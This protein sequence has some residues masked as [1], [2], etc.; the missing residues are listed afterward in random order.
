ML[1]VQW[2]NAVFGGLGVLSFFECVG[3]SVL[4]S[5]TGREVGQGRVKMCGG[6]EVNHMR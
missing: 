5:F 3:L 6:K 2:L 4:R 1:A